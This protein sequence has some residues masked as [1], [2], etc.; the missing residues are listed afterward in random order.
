[1]TPPPEQP[2]SPLVPHREVDARQQLPV[3]E[4]QVPPREL[5]RGARVVVVVGAVVVVVVD[6]TAGPCSDA[7]TDSVCVTSAPGSGK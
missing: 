3:L 5:S 4:Q 2:V 1:M 6:G 7:A